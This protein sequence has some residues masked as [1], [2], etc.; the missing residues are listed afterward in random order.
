MKKLLLF[1]MT[2]PGYLFL[3][4][5]DN[6]AK[7]KN[8]LVPYASVYAGGCVDNPFSFAAGVQQK[9]RDHL[10][11]GYDVHY[12]NTG[13]ECYCDDKYSKGKFSSI[14]PSVKLLYNT[15]KKE[16]RGFVAGVGLG[17]MFAKD[18]GSEVP[19]TYDPMTS[20]YIYQQDKALHDANW[21][22]NSIAPSFSIGAGFRLF[23]LPVTFQTI[24]YFAKTT[25]GWMPAAG[26]TGFTI[27]FRKLK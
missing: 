21:D 1:C 3:Q 17:Y 9:L 11:I 26:G 5:Q 6:S 4:A 12:W 19:Y 22:F 25:D 10:T 18:R 15:G 16:G 27:G 24:Y 23:K 13:Y 14:T 8:P 7:Q 2:I 20:T